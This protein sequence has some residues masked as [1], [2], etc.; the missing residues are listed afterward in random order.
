MA[1]YQ[2]DNSGRGPLKIPGFNSIPVDLQLSVDSQF[3]HGIIPYWHRPSRLTARELEMLRCMDEITDEVGW[4]DNVHDAKVVGQWRE[5]AFKEPMM[6][7]RAWN[8]CLSELKDKSVV[9]AKTSQVTTYDSAYPIAKS[10]R[11]PSRLREEIRDAVGSLLDELRRNGEPESTPSEQTLG[12]VDPSMFPLIYEESSVLLDGGRTDLK[13]MMA[14]F[15]ETVIPATPIIEGDHLGSSAAPA[16]DS[17]REYE[18]HRWSTRFQRLPCEVAFKEKGNVKVE[19]TSY[20]NNVHP[21][22]HKAFYTATEKLICAAISAWNEVLVKGDQGRKPL[23]I[24]TYGIKWGPE[25]PG[26]ACW[27]PKDPL[28]FFSTRT[29]MSNPAVRQAWDRLPNRGKYEGYPAQLTPEIIRVVLKEEYEKCETYLKLQEPEVDFS[30]S[31]RRRRSKARMIEHWE[32]CDFFSTIDHKH[33]W[34]QQLQHPEPGIS[35]TYDDWK[36]GRTSKAIVEKTLDDEESWYETAADKDHQYYNV[37]L[38]EEFQNEGL[39]VIIKVSTTELTPD[40]PKFHGSDWQ[41][42]GILNEHICATAMYTIDA[43]NI[44]PTRISLRKADF[45]DLFAWSWLFTGG[46]NPA[47]IFG[48]DYIDGNCVRNMDK[49]KACQVLGPVQTPQGRLLA[50]SSM[51]DHRIEPF[52][53]IDVTRPG[54]QTVLEMYLVDPHYRICSTRNVPPQRHD[55]WIDDAVREANLQNRLPQELVDLVSVHTDD[56]PIGSDE[57]NR[58]RLEMLEESQIADQVAE[59]EIGRYEWYIE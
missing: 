50:W 5:R 31:R 19:I 59:G 58:L 24:L 33:A 48:V 53:L 18:K 45:V 42:Q 6:S 40:R 23:R 43:E 1:T 38:E 14:D 54:S 55:W 27:N 17:E 56:W 49:A 21:I 28:F 39:Q 32:N 30:A 4:H 44:T 20:I 57:A 47:K 52:E 13:N 3:L 8:W 15:A 26:W 51:L 22:K 41:Q 9:F 7:E 36:V 16:R 25:R 29:D 2:F 46:E 10:E 11:V 37:A 34:L 12:I 35:F